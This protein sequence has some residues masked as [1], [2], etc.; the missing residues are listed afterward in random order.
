MPHAHKHEIA[1][2]IFVNLAITVGPKF[3]GEKKPGTNEEIAEV[4]KSHAAHYD[5]VLRE[6][7]L[8]LEKYYR[9]HVGMPLH[10]LVEAVG[11]VPTGEG[12][13]DDS[14]ITYGVCG[15]CTTENGKKGRYW[16]VNGQRQSCVSTGC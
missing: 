3:Y 15:G 16:Y 13:G 11:N 6:V 2:E 8:V 1:D 9:A 7:F 14:N 4:L 10:Q 12:S 5:G